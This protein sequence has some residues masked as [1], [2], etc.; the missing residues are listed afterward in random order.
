MKSAKVEEAIYKRA[1]FILRQQGYYLEKTAKIVG[2]SVYFENIWTNRCKTEGF[3]TET[4]EWW[5]YKK[6]KQILTP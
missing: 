6:F 1:V 3:D 5:V 4:R 2:N